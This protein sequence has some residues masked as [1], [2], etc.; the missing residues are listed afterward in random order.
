MWLPRNLE[1]NRMA[2]PRPI[3]VGKSKAATNQIA[4]FLRAI[5]N[6]SF[7]VSKIP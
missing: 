6:T 1:F 4:L 3:L 7:W 2:N 5:Q